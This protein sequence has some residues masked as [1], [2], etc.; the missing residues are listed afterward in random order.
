MTSTRYFIELIAG[1]LGLQRKSKH[2]NNAAIEM[3]LLR[4]AEGHL[5]AAIWRNTENIERLSNE[6]W[7]L[8]KLGKKQEDLQQQLKICQQKLEGA[9]DDQAVLL[10]RQAE[11]E[12][13]ELAE[14]RKA[15]LAELEDLSKQRDDVIREGSTIRRLYNGSK[16]KLE[17]LEGEADQ[18]TEEI[19][20]IKKRLAEFKLN[21]AEL[22][23]IRDETSEKIRAGDAEMDKI[24]AEMREHSHLNQKAASEAFMAMNQ[25]NK[26]VWKLRAE[27][28]LLEN[29]MHHHQLEIGRHISRHA[30]HDKQCATAAAGHQGLVDVMR[31]LRRSI[32]L[33]HKLAGRI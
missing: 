16:L 14:K 17:V 26:E 31:A 30:S 29:R 10:M 24:T 32:A 13:P 33:N 18:H 11:Y 9:N 5:G 8:R 4:E 19:E 21:F 1:T 27:I 7:T 25:V 28:G 3:H 20:N 15:L 2:F 6:Y 23:A 12:N 22:K